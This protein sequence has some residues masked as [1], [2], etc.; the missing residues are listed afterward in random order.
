M[1]NK[2]SRPAILI[3]SS[4]AAPV[5]GWRPKVP[6]G[7][8]R[9]SN[10]GRGNQLVRPPLPEPLPSIELAPV[11]SFLQ[12]ASSL[13]HAMQAERGA[14]TV[15]CASEGG[16]FRSNLQLLRAVTD[17]SWE[18]LS[19][20]SEGSLDFGRGR[21]PLLHGC[22]RTICTAAC[23]VVPHA[24]LLR[25]Q[26]PDLPRPADTPGSQGKHPPFLPRDR[27]HADA[28]RHLHALP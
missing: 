27:G 26:N 7:E 11:F 12:A 21:Q 14:S 8:A 2:S 16:Q 22:T 3:P 4:P 23:A 24:H 25:N 15:L 13:V 18:R 9:E 17:E 10:S 19:Q 20:A 5:Q 6:A 28:H 1:G